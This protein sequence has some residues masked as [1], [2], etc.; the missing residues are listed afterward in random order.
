MFNG[1]GFA[2]KS[3]ENGCFNISGCRRQQTA[4]FQQ[5]RRGGRPA[6][7]QRKIGQVYSNQFA[8]GVKR[9]EQIFSVSGYEQKWPFPIG[10][11]GQKH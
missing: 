8:R 1:E 7:R 11:E 2:V 3:A 10:R 4:T 9:G 5:T 6:D